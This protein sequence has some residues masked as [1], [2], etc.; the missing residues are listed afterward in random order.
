MASPHHLGR[1]NYSAP[2]L[3]AFI[4]AYG[5]PGLDVQKEAT[6][7]AFIVAAV[8]VQDEDLP[9][10]RAA[11]QA[12]R[13]THF[14]TG[15]IKSSHVGDND[16]RR[17]Q[18]LRNLLALPLEFAAVAFDKQRLWADGELLY[19]GLRHKQSF[20]KFTHRQLFEP[21]Y[22]KHVGLHVL[23]D[24]IGR[25]EYMDGF[26]GYA[27]NRQKSLFVNHTF[28][29]APSVEHELIQCADFIAGSLARIYDR[30]KVSPHTDEILRVLHTKAR[31]VFDWPKL[32]RRAPISLGA[33][34]HDDIVREFSR[35][36]VWA[37]LHGHDRSDDEEVVGRVE[38]LN[39]LLFACEVEDGDPWVA[40]RTLQEYLD[41]K[42]EKGWTEHQVR[43][44]I[45][46][47]LRDAGVL[48]A[49]SSSGYKI[50]SSA[51]DMSEFFEH[52]QRV[53]VPLVNRVRTAH[54][55]LL[56]ATD[57]GLNLLGLPQFAELRELVY[58][59]RL[60]HHEAAPRSLPLADSFI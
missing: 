30:K 53:V 42:T 12:V 27:L 13:R 22:S 37:Y 35:D 23:A 33:T 10:V 44:K 26:R 3:H 34:K 49:S 28:D 9:A 20:Y 5:D 50:P 15:P 2:P 4:D 41:H 38:A 60:P 11:A 40:T 39:R 48:I 1:G 51:A 31:F 29:F 32:F 14:Q 24:R 43:S 6:T 58:G 59:A 7:A 21:L 56:G 47:P 45:I 54:E 8:L 52:A 16:G 36:Q 57:S 46:A 19:P 17:M 55:A 25:E 18:V